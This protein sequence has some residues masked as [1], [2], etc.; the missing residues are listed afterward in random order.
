MYAILKLFHFLILWTDAALIT[1]V[2]Q[3]IQVVYHKKNHQELLMIIRLT[4]VLYFTVLVFPMFPSLIGY[5]TKYVE[6]SE[7]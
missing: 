4:F 5:E 7:L 1:C 3:S 6:R 2:P